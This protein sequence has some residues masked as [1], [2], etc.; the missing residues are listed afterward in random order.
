[1]PTHFKNQVFPQITQ[2][3]GQ[4]LQNPTNKKERQKLILLPSD[5]MTEFQKTFQG[6]LQECTKAALYEFVF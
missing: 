4:I 3:R 6:A 2:N 5:W 1:M